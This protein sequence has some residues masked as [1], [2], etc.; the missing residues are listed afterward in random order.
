MDLAD[1][2]LTAGTYYTGLDSLTGTVDLSTG[3]VTSG[4]T[5]TIN[6]V[7]ILFNE[8]KEATLDNVVLSINQAM[9][10]I[11]IDITASKTVGNE[12]ELLGGLQTDIEAF[13]TGGFSKAIWDI[14]VES[15]GDVILRHDVHGFNDG[16]IVTID[17]VLGMEEINE[18]EAYTKAVDSNYIQLFTDK[19][20]TTPLDGSSYNEFATTEV[21]S[22]AGFE[23][24]DTVG[25]D[26]AAGF[27]INGSTIVL[28]S[29]DT[30]DTVVTKINDANIV[31]VRARKIDID[32]GAGVTERLQIL[33]NDIDI[34][35]T[36]G[37]EG[38]LAAVGLVP[39]TSTPVYAGSITRDAFVDLGLTTGLV[40]HTPSGSIRTDALTSIGLPTSQT[41]AYKPISTITIASAISLA[42]FGLTAGTTVHI[43]SGD[44]V[45]DAIYELGLSP[46]L[47]YHV[48]SGHMD[49]DALM[50]YGMTAETIVWTDSSN[51]DEVIVEAETT[52]KR[53]GLDVLYDTF[54][55]KAIDGRTYSAYTGAG[56]AVKDAL[57]DLG[58]V[59]GTY[60]INLRK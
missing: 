38:A 26:F 17:N 49:T 35:L 21:T 19:A 46:S 56:E 27:L 36:N 48:P 45:H 44:V 31:D 15:D 20:L 24:T 10:G 9:T 22:G 40:S 16:D 3:T 51:D 55:L 28:A 7:E 14:T 2:G 5:V 57:T 47:V 18:V 54:D 59:P 43:P 52:L 4:E 12:L 13:S 30:I 34:V 39:G 8:C 60:A 6:G 25:E 58:I 37:D 33:G 23:N 32:E 11:G 1:L 50:S 42:R 29:A 53:L 41:V